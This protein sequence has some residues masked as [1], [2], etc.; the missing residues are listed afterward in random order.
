MRIHLLAALFVGSNVVAATLAA[1][2]T[3]YQHSFALSL[4]VLA[5]SFFSLFLILI[6]KKK[7][8]WESIL[9]LSMFV[10]FV[11]CIY[12]GYWFHFFAD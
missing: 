8:T 4:L 3:E 10:Y 2:G 5:S 7:N 6:R 11:G 12:Y 9:L 1:S